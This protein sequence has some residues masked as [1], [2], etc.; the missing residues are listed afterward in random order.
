MAVCSRGPYLWVVIGN[1]SQEH[2][3]DGPSSGKT[4]GS[5]VVF[6][7]TYMTSLFLFVG[8]ACS[9]ILY[10]VYRVITCT[11]SKKTVTKTTSFLEPL[12][13]KQLEKK[14]FKPCPHAFLFLVPTLF[15][16]G[17]TVMLNFS[18]FF[19]VVSVQQT[20]SNF[21]VVFVALFL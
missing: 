8:E 9:L 3:Y 10:G 21:V 1:S 13:I 17:A 4:G 12:S 15:D 7:H 6:D 5:P 19:V 11:R 16:L 14:P 18:I 2:G 20:I